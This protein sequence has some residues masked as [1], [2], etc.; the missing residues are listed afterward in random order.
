VRR[1]TLGSTPSDEAATKRLY[2]G[3]RNITT[4]WTIP[5]QNWKPV[6]S[7]LM[8]RFNKKFNSTLPIQQIQNAGH[9]PGKFS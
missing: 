7:R 6:M 2:L 1:K 5:I 4:A 3:I 8:I 9:A